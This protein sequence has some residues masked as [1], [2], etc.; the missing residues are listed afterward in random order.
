MKKFFRIFV[1][2]GLLLFFLVHAL[3]IVNWPLVSNIDGMLYDAYLRYRMPN[4]ID[5]RI[6]IID[7]DEKSLAQEG[8]WPWSR[9]RLSQLIQKL[10]EQHHV[11]L[12]GFDI[13]FAEHDQSSGLLVLEKLARTDLKDNQNYQR[14]LPHL[15]RLLNYDQLFASAIAPYPIVLG[16]Y[17]TSGESARI[18]GLLPKPALSNQDFKDVLN[19]DIANWNG[20]GANIAELQQAAKTAG[21]FNQVPDADGI[22][23]RVPILIQYNKQFYSSLSLAILRT[24]LDAGYMS[25]RT[26]AA[27]GIDGVDLS[28]PRGELKIPTDQQMNVLIPYRG[29]TGPK[30]NAFQYISATDV[31]NGQLPNSIQLRDKIILIGTTAPGLKDLR[32]TPVSRLYPGVEIHANLISGMLDGK[33]KNVPDYAQGFEITQLLIIGLMA[34]LLLPYLSAIRAIVFALATAIILFAL[35]IYFYE[36]LNLLL[37][38][39]SVLLFLLSLFLF[40]MSFGYLTESSAKRQITSLFGSYVPPELVTQMAK[41]PQSYKLE[42]ESREITVLF[43]DVRGFTSISEAL[44]PT[45]LREYINDYLTRMSFIIRDEWQGTLD[46]YVGD[47]IM[48]FWGAPIQES[49]HAVKAIKAGLKMQQ[50]AK[51]MSAE[52]MLRNLPTLAIGVGINTG[53]V[54]VGDMGSK[55]RRA[56]T[57]LGDAVNLGA[58]L[59]GLTKIYGVGVIVGQETQQQATQHFGWRELDC[60]RVKGKGQATTI[61]EPIDLTMAQQEMVQRELD[62]WHTALSLYR[63]QKWN[64]SRDILHYLIEMHP[65]KKLYS[66]YIE[67]IENFFKFPPPETW[68]TVTQFENK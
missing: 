43:S 27:Q 34:S 41:N 55:I 68:D 20:Y 12:V 21:H 28:G 44:K 40:N 63:Q 8:R 58:R 67:R 2:F 47:E 7:I 62:L 61:F 56:Y 19:L 37:P 46:K 18:N 64:E 16:Y 30:G 9:N 1:A 50:E 22:V 59:E 26:S 48:A 5:P 53:V 38:L 6:V 33:L 45:E 65:D 54:S 24:Y 31:L 49:Q 60:V 32:A 39:A 14:E 42:G 3:K 15:R 51:K 17:F 52:F 4:T 25:V 10:F 23:R 36:Q 13:V 57:V 35:H 66:L 29:K 11:A